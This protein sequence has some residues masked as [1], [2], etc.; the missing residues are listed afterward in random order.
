[1]VVKLDVPVTV[2]NVAAEFAILRLRFVDA[3]WRNRET[4]HFELCDFEPES[5]PVGER[6]AGR[7]LE[8]HATFE[9]L[10]A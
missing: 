5:K 7:W 10:T 1:M 8:S 6:R 3:R 2:D 4:V 9:M